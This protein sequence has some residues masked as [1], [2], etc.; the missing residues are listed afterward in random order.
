MIATAQVGG[1]RGDRGGQ[2]EEGG[3]GGGG[4]VDNHRPFIHLGPFIYGRACL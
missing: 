1:T 4:G 2:G 3:G